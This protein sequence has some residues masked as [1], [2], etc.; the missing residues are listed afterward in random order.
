M[1]TKRHILFMVLLIAIFALS[2]L[3]PHHNFWLLLALIVLIIAWF[4]TSSK[5]WKKIEKKVKDDALV[6]EEEAPQ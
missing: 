4:A 1:I 6:S 3:F 5:F 2:V